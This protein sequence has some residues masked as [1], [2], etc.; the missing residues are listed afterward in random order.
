VASEDKLFLSLSLIFL[1]VGL[2]GRF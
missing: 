1:R 2:I